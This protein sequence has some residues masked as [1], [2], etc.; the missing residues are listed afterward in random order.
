MNRHER[1]RE[2]KLAGA[3]PEHSSI[4]QA[5]RQKHL[6]SVQLR[7]VSQDIREKLNGQRVGT[8]YHVTTPE[9]VPVI[10]RDGFRASAAQKGLPGLVVTHTFDPGVWFADVPPITAI[11]VDQFMGYE[12]E[13]WIAVFVTEEDYNQHFVG[14]EWQDTSWPTRQ[15]LISET[16][17][18]SFVRCEVPLSEV[19][20]LRI[21]NVSTQHHRYY[22]AKV[23][24]RQIQN[25]MSGDTQARWLAALNAAIESGHA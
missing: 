13:A 21:A 23:L 4:A 22:T 11:S 14:N 16:A 3:Y 17:A 7:T 12:D 5:R 1:R 25:E 15:W 19:L 10:L 20:R 18:N 2:S 8:L 6:D 24:Q 9:I